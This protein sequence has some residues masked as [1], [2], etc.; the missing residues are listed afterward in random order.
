VTYSTT[1]HCCGAEV[2]TANSNVNPAWMYLECLVN[3]ELK[4]IPVC[5]SC[6]VSRIIFDEA[7][8]ELVLMEAVK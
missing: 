1:C 3:G 2:R 6:V 4:D 7:L 8:Q 5:D